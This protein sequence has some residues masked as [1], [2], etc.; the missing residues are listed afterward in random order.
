MV[1]RHRCELIQD[2][3]LLDPA[4]SSY[5]VLELPL[6]TPSAYPITLLLL[7]LPLG[8]TICEA[9]RTFIMSQCGSVDTS[10]SPF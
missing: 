3:P 8:D 4:H 6:R 2:L 7:I 9:T 10:S 1:P 5:I